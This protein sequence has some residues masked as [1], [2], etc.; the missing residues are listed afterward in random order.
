MGHKDG[1]E[2]AM[3]RY[4]HPRKESVKRSMLERFADHER[5]RAGG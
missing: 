2:M 1:G 5:R 4:I 3:K